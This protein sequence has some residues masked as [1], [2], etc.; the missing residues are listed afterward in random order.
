[1][2][3]SNTE[4]ND[5]VRRMSMFNAESFM[6]RSSWHLKPIK[7]VLEMDDLD[8]D[9]AAPWS[10]PLDRLVALGTAGDHGPLDAVQQAMERIM[11]HGYCDQFFEEVL[12]VG[13]DKVATARQMLIDENSCM[14]AN[15]IPTQYPHELLEMMQQLSDRVKAGR[16]KTR[17]AEEDAYAM[18]AQL[19]AN[20][21]E[22][23]RIHAIP[24]Y[25][26]ELLPDSP[27][28]NP[29]AIKQGW[30]D[31]WWQSGR[32][33]IAE[34]ILAAKAQQ[35]ARDDQRDQLVFSQQE[36]LIGQ[37]EGL[38]GRLAVLDDYSDMYLSAVESLD[39]QKA[40]EL[41][42]VKKE[43]KKLFD[44]AAVDLKT[45]EDKLAE[46]KKKDQDARRDYDTTAEYIEQFLPDNQRRIE[47]TEAEIKKLD[48]W[49]EAEK[50]RRIY[51][52]MGLTFNPA[53]QALQKEVEVIRKMLEEKEEEL[54]REND[55]WASAHKDAGADLD[56]LLADLEAPYLEGHEKLVKIKEMLL[57]ERQ[58]WFE[59]E[60]ARKQQEMTR[61]EKVKHAL[62]KW[63]ERRETLINTAQMYAQ[64]VATAQTAFDTIQSFHQS[65][66]KFL[67]AAQKESRVKAPSLLV[68]GLEVGAQLDQ[69]LHQVDTNKR[70]RISSVDKTI[71][72]LNML[73]EFTVDT[74][75]PNA[76]KYQVILDGL[77]EM[78]DQLETDLGD[79]AKIDEWIRRE[80]QAMHRTISQQNLS[81]QDAHL[82]SRA[83]KAY[84]A[85]FEALGDGARAEGLRAA[86][87]DYPTSP[88][89]MSRYVTSANPMPRKQLRPL[90][91]APAPY[92]DI[93][94]K[95]DPAPMT[96]GKAWLCQSRPGS[97]Q[98]AQ[99]ASAA[100]TPSAIRSP[101]I[102]ST[103][104]PGHLQSLPGHSP[105]AGS[106]GSAVRAQHYESPTARISK[107]RLRSMSPTRFDHRYFRVAKVIE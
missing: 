28:D 14:D 60:P 3:E 73:L 31:H 43:T 56:G 67:D 11:S 32:R 76:H 8:V 63:E 49:Y 66:K 62:E 106:P 15:L 54:A 12:K 100:S 93:C 99:A 40:L 25:N 53:A 87:L 26:E 90:S 45:I 6:R 34:E 47:D 85:F 55:L 33:Q 50:K 44:L 46:V 94:T 39:D 77:V 86:R 82:V 35:W 84:P 38:K 101:S 52:D 10:L 23:T 102:A 57:S 92:G 89:P 70:D 30:K 9:T 91:A 24:R 1:M 64:T 103:P 61:C 97:A 96:P 4:P 107:D 13:K 51:S 2:E 41:V 105:A 75:D 69:L 83:R 79:N 72:H 59:Q 48:K 42:E 71:G 17:T 104:S 58:K 88:L 98:A 21:E 27:P 37:F 95:L 29:D 20:V 74:H 22:L 80:V 36:L 18:H 68:Q 5:D 81:P 78:R 19:M 65:I 7:P 16:R